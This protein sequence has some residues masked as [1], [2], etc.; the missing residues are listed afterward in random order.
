MRP[1]SIPM[2]FLA[3]VSILAL[4]LGASLLVVSAAEQ[5]YTIAVIPMAT[6]HE[7]CKLIYAGAL[8]AQAGFKSRGVAVD[9]IW[10]GPPRQYD[11]HHQVQV[12]ENFIGRQ[13]SGIVL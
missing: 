9:I 7:Y 12:V 11:R 6:T 13:V 10:K 2:R 5:N 8:M 3:R 4:M 1:T